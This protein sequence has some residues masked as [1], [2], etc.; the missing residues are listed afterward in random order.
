MEIK[1]AVLIKTDDLVPNPDNPN[2]MSEEQL[3]KLCEQISEYGFTEPLM[4]GPADKGKHEIIAGHHRH[5]AAIALGLAKVPCIIYENWDKDKRDVVMLRMNIVKGDLNPQKFMKLF[6][7]FANQYGEKLAQ[8]MIGFTDKDAF[9]EI[10]KQLKAGLPK[11]VQKKLEKAEENKEIGTV[12]DLTKTVSDLLA[13]YGESVP[14]NFVHFNHGGKQHIMQR[15]DDELWKTISLFY[16]GCEAEGIDSM[17]VFKILMK[18]WEDVVFR[19]QKPQRLKDAEKN[20]GVETEGGIDD[21]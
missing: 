21:E 6:D 8:E 1:K 12:E 11:D 7:K 17:M 18:G 3:T 4:V 2:V 5:K 13:D 16:K 15:C 10:K 9:N 19:R 20:E 14:Y